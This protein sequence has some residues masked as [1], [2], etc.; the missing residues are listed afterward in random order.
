LAHL[1]PEV[2]D[3]HVDDFETA[4]IDTG[5]FGSFGDLGFRA[6]Q[7][8][9]NQA[10]LRGFYSTAQSCGLAGMSDGGGNR[11][12]RFTA[13]QQ[14]FVLAGTGRAVHARSFK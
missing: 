7:D 5:E 11:G 1:A 14:F 9:S 12:E 13:H 6:D 3:G 4:E 8:R 10:E 2:Q